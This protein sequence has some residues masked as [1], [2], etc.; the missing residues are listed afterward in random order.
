[1]LR[2]LI[3]ALVL[4][5]SGASAQAQEL[6]GARQ[7]FDGKM[8]PKVEV[9][10]FEHSEKIFPVKVV[11]HEGP[12]RPLPGS[13]K[14]LKN[15]SFESGGNAF[16]LFDYLAYNRVAGLL[17]L[18]DGQV[19]LED[20]ELGTGSETRWPSFSMAKSV[21][22]TLVGAALQQG[23]IKSLDEPI[24]QYL[25]EL[26]GGA[27]EGASIRNV[28][29]M[30][31][32]VKWD[33][34]YTD[35]Q[36]DRRKLLEAQLT[37]K[38]GVILAHMNSLQ[39]AGAPGSIWSYSTGESFLVGAILERATHKALASYLSE[40]LWVPLGMEKDATWWTESKGGMGLSGS[41]LGAT[42][43]DYGRFGLFVQQD[44]VID[45]KRIVPEGWFRDA[46]SA[47]MIG[48]KKVD[49]GYF[50]WPIPAG[51]PIHQDAFQAIGIFGQHM[52]INPKEKLVIVVLSARPKP[53]SSTHTLSDAAFF[54]AVARA[55]Q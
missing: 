53:D 18:K 9:A 16:D 45:G 51:D 32:G 47:H 38:P 17:I 41:G 22:S 34:T 13:A 7:V 54:A 5:A 11:E 1:M 30:A 27:Y 15:I 29:Q 20:Y 31:S 12:A 46:G 33:E 19:V 48:G 23:L 28:L 50:W 55:L 49:Y 10:T 42:L 4:M 44:G 35:P 24:T 2:R 26:K 6:A 43:R 37:L 25:P 52:Y 21:S 3:F 39:K 36:S 14:S 8:L 40:T